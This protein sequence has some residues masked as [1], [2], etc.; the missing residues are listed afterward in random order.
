MAAEGAARAQ[1]AA[2]VSLMASGMTVV[3][4]FKA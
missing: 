2:H 4:V 3:V 1:G